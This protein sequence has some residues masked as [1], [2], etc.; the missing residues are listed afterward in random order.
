M[1]TLD[2]LVIEGGFRTKGEGDGT[3]DGMLLAAMPEQAG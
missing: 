1:Q 3:H 2:G